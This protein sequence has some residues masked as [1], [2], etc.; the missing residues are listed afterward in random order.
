MYISYFYCLSRFS[1]SWELNCVRIKVTNVPGA[2]GVTKNAFSVSNAN[3]STR[4]WSAVPRRRHAGGVYQAGVLQGHEAPD[5]LRVFRLSLH[6][7]PGAHFDANIL[8]SSRR[9]SVALAATCQWF[10]PT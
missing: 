8:A 1:S 5:D 6:A 10:A 3:A 9:L 4:P 7:S 2:F